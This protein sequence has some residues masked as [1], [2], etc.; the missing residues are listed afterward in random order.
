MPTHVLKSKDGT[1]YASYST[2]EL[3]Q[4]KGVLQVYHEDLEK[5]ITEK[6][7]AMSTNCIQIL[8]Q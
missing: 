2:P 1:L 6:K 7:L 3:K 5:T 8:E 4:E